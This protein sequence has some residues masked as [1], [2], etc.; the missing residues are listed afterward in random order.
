MADRFTYADKRNL[1]PLLPELFGILYENMQE[2]DF[3]GKTRE[4]AWREW[5]TCVGPAL[6]KEARQLVLMHRDGRLVGFFQYYVRMDTKTLM[7]EEIQI[8]RDCQG[9][10]LFRGL[11]RWLVQEL[12]CDILWVEAFAN[13]KNRKSLALLHVLGLAI[14]E[15]DRF[16][17]LKG[18]YGELRRWVEGNRDGTSSPVKRCS[19]VNENNPLYVRYHDGEWGVPTHDDRELFELLILEG[20]QAGLSWECVLNK[21]QNFRAAFDGFDVDKVSLYGETDRERLQE[22]PGIVR[23]RRKITAAVTNA[24]VFTEI[25]RECGSFDAYIWSFTEGKTVAE[26]Y[27]QRTTS[28]LSDAIS[29][30]LKKR[31]MCFVGSTII[32][33]YLQAIGVINGHG[34][35]CDCCSRQK[36]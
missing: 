7:M 14:T 24:R 34:N 1:E 26:P 10:G 29:R 31:G 2:M 25:Q 17:R 5:Q 32:Y 36:N 3:P 28:P 13:K 21:R 15:E 27:T 11:Y 4:E 6:Q 30:D 20:F 18:R 8:R 16:Y 22:D 23:N 35:E 9:T 19:W 33:S 12:P